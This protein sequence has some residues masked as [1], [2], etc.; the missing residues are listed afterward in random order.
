MAGKD[1]TWLGALSPGYSTDGV[2]R[3]HL[4]ARLLLGKAMQLCRVIKR[5]TVTVTSLFQEGTTE[6][7]GKGIP[8]DG[9]EPVETGSLVF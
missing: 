5:E 8:S 6:R 2:Q 9:Y 4:R 3:E 7:S 1:S